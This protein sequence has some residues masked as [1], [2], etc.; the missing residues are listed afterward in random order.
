MEISKNNDDDRTGTE[1]FVGSTTRG[2]ITFRV[3]TLD[4]RLLGSGHGP[5]EEGVRRRR[6]RR[7]RP[8]T[9]PGTAP[10]KHGEVVSGRTTTRSSYF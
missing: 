9:L 7:R 3:Y 10:N 6:R 4:K 5:A 2:S 1:T 8:R